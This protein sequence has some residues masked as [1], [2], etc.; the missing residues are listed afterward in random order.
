MNKLDSFAKVVS[1]IRDLT[2]LVCLLIVTISTFVELRA[3]QNIHSFSQ[4]VEPKTL[5]SDV[6]TRNEANKNDPNEAYQEL[7]KILSEDIRNANSALR[8]QANQISSL[9]QRLE[10]LEN[11]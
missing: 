11:R 8:E 3:L 5:N 4:V 2:L 7:F 9:S 1:L 10:R 6:Q